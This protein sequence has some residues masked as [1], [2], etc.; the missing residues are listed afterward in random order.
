MNYIIEI[1]QL[2]PADLEILAQVV[3][4]YETLPGWNQPITECR[5]F[6]SLPENAQKYI[7]R[8]EEL[9]GVPVEWIGVGP[10]RDAMIHCA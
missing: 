2:T 6:A 4:E 7:K 9:V 5:T 1:N 3:V 8:V 10:S